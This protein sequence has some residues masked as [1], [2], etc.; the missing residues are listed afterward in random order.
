MEAISN[1]LVP[2]IPEE[3][4]SALL[5]AII[6]EGDKSLSVIAGELGLSVADVVGL[7]SS[8]GFVKEMQAVT[9]A[10]ANIALRGAGI[11]ELARIATSAEKEGD[12]LTA[13][14]TLAQITGDLKAQSQV[15]VRVSFDDLRRRR[16]DDE[17]SSLF[18][19]KS[20]V[21]EGEIE[22]VEIASGEVEE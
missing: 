13:I 2:V 22:E 20:A 21:V 4:R 5:L 12:R 18:D 10:Q 14:R 3:T 6:G 9:R 16:S 8:P 7:L 1:S 11:K 19:I 15:E 17:L